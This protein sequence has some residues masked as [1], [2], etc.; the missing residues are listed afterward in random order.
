MDCSLPG[1]SV[2][3]IS[4][5]RILEWVAISL[6]R[7]SSWPEF[8]PV[9][10][11][12]AGRFFTTELPRK[13]CKSKFLLILD[14]LKCQ[15]LLVARPLCGMGCPATRLLWHPE[16]VSL[17]ALTLIDIVYFPRQSFR[18]EKT[19]AVCCSSVRLPGWYIE[20]NWSDLNWPRIH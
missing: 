20:G 17:T 10:P 14:Q 6:P 15:F 8:K 2:H 16:H 4:Q 12:L 1:S 3:G 5:A 13:L 11:S 9:S 19:R 18:S 7:R